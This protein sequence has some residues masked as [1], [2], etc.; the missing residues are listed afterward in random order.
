MKTYSLTRYFWVLL[1]LLALGSAAQAQTVTY[2]QS[3]DGFADGVTELGDGSILETTQEGAAGIDN[4]AMKLTDAAI[5][6]TNTGWVIPG[7]GE[8]AIAGWTATFY[9]ALSG[10]GA[11]P[12]DGFSFNWGA[13]EGGT[14]GEEGY[15]SGLA[16]EFDTWDNG[17]EGFETGIGID[18]RSGRLSRAF[19][20]QTSQIQNGRRC[21][22]LVSIP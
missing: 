9:L 3:F 2:L 1:T 4:E 22:R 15:G 16:I 10:G 20:L 8:P 13:F 11:S 5:G 7:L 18:V 17:G 14:A 12:A 19:R 6:S 21:R